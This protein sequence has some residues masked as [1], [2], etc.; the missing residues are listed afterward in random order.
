[1]VDALPLFP[2]GTVLFPHAILPL[3][4]F[5]PRY[6]A[7]MHDLM[8]QP[9]PWSFGVV[10][11][12][13]GHE[14]GADSVRSLYDVGCTA[15]V[16]QAEQLPDGRFAV[17]LVG[18]DRFRI[19]EVDG[20]RPYLQASVDVLDEPPVVDGALDALVA[21]VRQRCTDY[22]GTLG[23]AAS[24]QDLPADPTPL[25][26]AVAAAL[27]VGLADRQAL[28]ETPDTALRLRA[29]AELLKRELGVMRTLRAMPVT[30]QQLP[31]HSQN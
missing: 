1:M 22:L 28:L 24:T 4:I 25:S 2:L 27:V 15:L 29:E 20:S 3:H 31:R 7:L 10:A 17:L 30:P 16:R 19:R 5:E 6:R 8:A 12:R 13:E 21:T 23:N 9:E 14:V 26:Y 18:G 11:I